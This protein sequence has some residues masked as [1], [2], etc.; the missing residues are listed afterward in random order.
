[1]K[2]IPLISIHTKDGLFQ[3]GSEVDLG[4]AEAE[5]MIAAG[6]VIPAAKQPAAEPAQ[7]KEKSVGGDS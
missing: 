3:P 7:K 2:V 5:A 1:M 4:K 6:S